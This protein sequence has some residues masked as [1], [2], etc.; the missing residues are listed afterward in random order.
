MRIGSIY[1][2]TSKRDAANENTFTVDIHYKSG[3]KFRTK[4]IKN[5]ELHES[6][7]FGPFFTKKETAPA[8]CQNC[9]FGL[10]KRFFHKKSASDNNCS[11]RSSE[12]IDKWFS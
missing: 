2:I 5:M 11:I 1:K 4:T 6:R 3:K 12:R 9:I 10:F 7:S 8:E